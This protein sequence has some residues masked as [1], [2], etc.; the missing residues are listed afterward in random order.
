MVRAERAPLARRVA[1]DRLRGGPLPYPAWLGRWPAALSVAA[2]TWV[3]LV[4]EDRDD[5]RTLAA[6]ALV[7]AVCA[8]VVAYEAIR[9]REHRGQVRHPEIAR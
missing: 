4:Y 8:F 5:P 1:G 6:L 7:S 3:E 2:F 9:H